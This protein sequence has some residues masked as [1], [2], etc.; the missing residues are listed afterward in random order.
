MEVALI[1]ESYEL[2]STL[3]DARLALQDLLFLAADFLLLKSA[4]S[5]AYLL[6]CCSVFNELICQL[7]YQFERVYLLLG[8]LG[9]PSKAL[10]PVDQHLGL[11]ILSQAHQL[12]NLALLSIHGHFVPI[13]QLCYF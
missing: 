2:S 5:L 4:C 8:S 3:L 9:L 1:Q 10:S 11:E 6:T 7:S 12:V 13:L